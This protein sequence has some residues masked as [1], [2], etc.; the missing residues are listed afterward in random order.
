MNDKT[1]NDIIRTNDL[2]ALSF[3]GDWCEACKQLKPKVDLL[4]Q[5]YK[6]IR[7]L[8]IDVHKAPETTQRYLITTIPTIIYLH[9][10]IPRSSTYGN[11]RLGDMEQTLKDFLND[12]K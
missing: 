1:I 7:F 11:V 8:T 4:S 9:K 2:V 12:A 5:A 6:S 3:T 10:G